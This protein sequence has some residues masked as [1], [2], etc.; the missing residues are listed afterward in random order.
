VYNTERYLQKCLDSL[1]A[2]T[3]PEL[4]IL[5]ID[6]GSTDS[7]PQICD[8][9]ARQ[10]SRV[11][12]IHQE[13]GGYAKAMNTGLAAAKGDYVGNLDSDDYVEDPCMFADLWHLAHENDL[14]AVKSDY[15]SFVNLN[16]QTEETYKR[17]AF[18][19]L[20]GMVLNP[21]DFLREPSHHHTYLRI[22]QAINVVWCG[23][24][25][26]EMLTNAEVSFNTN[27]RH[28]QDNG[29]YWQSMA[30]IKRMMFVNRAYV[31]HR[32]DNPA[33]SV[34]NSDGQFDFFAEHAFDE[35][36]LRRIG[37]WETLRQPFRRRK[38]WNYL[39]ALTAVAYDRKF[40]FI[41][42][43]SAEFGDDMQNGLTSAGF[44]ADEWGSLRRCVSDPLE[45]F[46]EY[47]DQHF[48]V[49]VI[50]P[51]YNA[52]EYLRETLDSVVNQSLRE[53][54]IILVDD[55][56]TDN[57]LSIMEEYRSADPLCRICVIS[58][59]NAGGGAARNAGLKQAHGQF[60]SILDADDVFD[61]RMLEQAYA[62]ASS[63]QADICIFRCVDF[64]HK[65]GLKT[66]NWNCVPGDFPTRRTF[67][68][69]D[70][71]GN[72]F[73]IMGF[74]WDKL[75]RRS[76]VLENGF[77]FQALPNANDAFFTYSALLNSNRITFLDRVLVRR[78]IETGSNISRHL[79]EN[80]KAEWTYE[81]TLLDYMRGLGFW[82]TFATDFLNAYAGHWV[83]R[84]EHLKTHCAAN[85]MFDLTLT[86]WLPNFPVLELPTWL[87]QPE[88]STAIGMLRRIGNYKVGDYDTFLA[89]L[90]ANPVASGSSVSQAPAEREPSHHGS[91]VFVTEVPQTGNA[92]SPLLQITTDPVKFSSALAVIDVVATT[93]SGQVF[94]DSL[95][96][97]VDFRRKSG[98]AWLRIG[99]TFWKCGEPTIT[100]N[101][102]YTTNVN[103]LTLWCQH[104]GI[105]A[106][107]SCQLQFIENRD[108]VSTPAVMVLRDG[109]VEIPEPTPGGFTIVQRRYRRPTLRKQLA[110]TAWLK[111]VK[112]MKRLL[113]TVWQRSQPAQLTNRTHSSW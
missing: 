27:V 6:D 107:F 47:V 96:L 71:K 21:N 44:T 19:E 103:T 9:Y 104:I 108:A 24:Y 63:T 66:R 11:H 67:K 110:A 58:Q 74:A 22:F 3:L 70:M 34:K 17:A 37:S 60:L 92:Y 2:Q 7:S 45:W 94:R 84:F 69:S 52:A 16:G 54:E 59:D 80:W 93:T 68:L 4:E 100:R 57:S 35:S 31:H 105:E 64:S 97:S 12:V 61:L 10:D 53:I 15:I 76:F 101:V 5:V 50:M 82:S 30:S 28:F 26:R 43:M 113:L 109:L 41:E 79:D 91:A 77:E 55:G 42:R 23:I 102:G 83:Y 75:F 88:H 32:K 33:Q 25:R 90:K 1:T 73:H 62:R 29:F 99:Q 39:M 65:T 18:P 56:S 13:N 78:R 36:S 51:I 38:W 14:D 86:D 72:P 89:D 40:E 85:Q 112:K 49:S 111:P 95:Y 87:I 81:K 8:E 98:N 106:S 46:T 48:K 20:Y